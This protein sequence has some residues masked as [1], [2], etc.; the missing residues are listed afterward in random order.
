MDPTQEDRRAASLLLRKLGSAAQDR[1]ARWA[2]E[3]FA[4]GDVEGWALWSRVHKA[5]DELRYGRG[6]PLPR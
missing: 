6:R 3:R 5:I 1:A 2:K 4:R